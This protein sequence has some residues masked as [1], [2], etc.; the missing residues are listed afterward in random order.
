MNRDDKATHESN[1]LGIPLPV[2]RVINKCWDDPEFKRRLFA[3]PVSA[4]KAEG[5]TLPEGVRVR[6]VEDTEKTLHLVLPNQ[7]GAKNFTGHSPAAAGASIMYS[8][9][10]K[11]SD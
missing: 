5:V 4:L 9:D 2:L 10:P 6:V 7:Q 1:S 8:R 11:V 3:D